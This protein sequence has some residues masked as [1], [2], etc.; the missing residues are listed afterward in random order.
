MDGTWRSSF[1]AK[2]PDSERQMLHISF[3][4]WDLDL[5]TNKKPPKQNKTKKPEKIRRGTI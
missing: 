2:E 5:K 1:Q 4:M 3:H